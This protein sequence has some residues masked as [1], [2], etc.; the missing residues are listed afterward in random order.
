[1][2]DHEE[3]HILLEGDVLYH[4]GGKTLSAKGP[5]IT[6]VPAGVPHTFI[7]TGNNP[8]HLIGVFPRNHIVDKDV[9]Q[10]L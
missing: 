9:G 6:R 3:A 1:V 5:Y 8:F 4:I 7:N 10:I 2:H